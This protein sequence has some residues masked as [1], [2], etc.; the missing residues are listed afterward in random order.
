MK[1]IAM[2]G[3]AVF[4]VLI[5]AFPLAGC[6]SCDGLFAVSDNENADIKL[7]SF[8]ECLEN[9]DRAGIKSL[10]AQNKI[11]DLADFDKSIEELFRYYDGDFVSFTR[12]STGVEKDKDSGIERKWYN[13]SYD[14]TTIVG[15]YRM[16]FIW[17]VKDTGDDNNVGI[18]SCYILKSADYTNYTQ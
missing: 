12:Y 5:C 4:I 16:A 17:C 6:D 1:R 15:I 3:L 18:E 8:V 9:E 14:V 7:E 10:F 11:A 13:M 2:V